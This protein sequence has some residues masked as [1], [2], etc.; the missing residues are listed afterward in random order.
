MWSQ[1]SVRLFVVPLILMTL[2]LNGLL[3]VFDVLRS[4]VIALCVLLWFV[5]MMPFVVSNLMQWNPLSASPF[6]P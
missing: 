6:S 5:L 4:V 1:F 2:A 3:F